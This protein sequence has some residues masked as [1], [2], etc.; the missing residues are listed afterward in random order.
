MPDRIFDF[1]KMLCIEIMKLSFK[2]HN[3]IKNIKG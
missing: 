2:T 1:S 3:Y